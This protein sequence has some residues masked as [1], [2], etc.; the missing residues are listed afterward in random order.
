MY[1]LY[2]QKSI[3]AVYIIS[4]RHQLKII[5]VVSYSKEAKLE[6]SAKQYYTSGF[7]LSEYNDIVASGAANNII[8]VLSDARV[9]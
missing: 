9:H 7:L 6:N 2:Y 1:Y 8:T 4:S 3:Y 5:P